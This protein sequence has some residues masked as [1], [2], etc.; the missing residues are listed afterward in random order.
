MDINE[1]RKWIYKTTP[2]KIKLVDELIS[3]IKYCFND[4][5]EVTNIK[6]EDNHLRLGDLTVKSI[7]IDPHELGG[8]LVHW[9]PN[10]K[11]STKN[12]PYCSAYI[13]H[14]HEIRKLIHHVNHI[15]DY[16]EKVTICK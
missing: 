1:T 14:N 3:S 11:T 12:D 9:Y 10:F 13:L 15:H 4:K 16:Y 8:V 5:I 7:E 2:L 6:F